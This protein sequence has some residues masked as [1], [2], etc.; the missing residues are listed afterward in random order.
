[1]KQIN[2]TV[3]V[4]SPLAPVPSVPLCDVNANGTVDVFDLILVAQLLGQE[5]KTRMDA[6]G[7]R[8]VNIFDMIIVA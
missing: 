1:M 5:S 7:D 4:S 8:L 6:N 3:T 2:T